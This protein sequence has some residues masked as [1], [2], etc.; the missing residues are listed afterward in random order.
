MKRASVLLLLLALPASAQPSNPA[1]ASEAPVA[2]PERPSRAAR[3]SA[4]MG[5]GTLTALGLGLAGALAGGLVG[6]A[7]CGAGSSGAFDLSGACPALGAGVL[8]GAGVLVGL[9]LGV[10]WGGQWAGGNG[11]FSGAFAGL[12]VSLASS[13]TAFL[14]GGDDVGTAL[15]IAAPLFSAVGYELT[16]SAPESPASFTVTPT[17]SMDSRGPGLGLRGRF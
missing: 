5:G 1:F 3:L 14:L 13:G 2:A 4:E 10:T 7:V 11:R 12:G 16:D 8:G 17:V 6:L 9:P 15:L